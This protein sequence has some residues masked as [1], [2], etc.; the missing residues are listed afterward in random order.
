MRASSATWPKTLASVLS[1]RD[2]ASWKVTLASIA[3]LLF[4]SPCWALDKVSL[5]LKW[6]H[7]FQFAGYYAALE[8]GFYRDA[9][10][11][12]EIREGGPNIDAMKAVEQGKADFG[13]CTT[14]VLLEKP[15]DPR[16][17]VLG[18]I[19]QHSPAVILVPSRVRIGALS[20]L[21]GRRFMDSP[22]SGDIAAMLKHE[23]IDYASLPR[24]PHD[25]D[26]RDLVTGKADIMIAYSTNEPFVLDQL[27]IPYQTFSPRQFGFDFYGDNLCTSAQQIRAHPERTRAFLAAS[28][29]GWDYALSHKNGMAQLILNRYSKKKTGEALLFEAVQSETLIEPRLIPIGSQTAQRWQSIANA[30]RDLGMLSD[31]RLPDGLIYRTDRDRAARWLRPALLGLVLLTIVS[32]LLLPLYKRINRRL[33]L[34]ANKPKLSTIMAGVFVCLSI[35]ILIFILVYNY[36]RNSEAIL[37]TLQEVVTK[38]RQA[39]IENVEAMI[40]DVAGTLGLLAEMA[41][42][43]PS[44]FRTEK[45]RDVLYRAVTSAAEIDAAYVSFEDGYHRVVTRIDDDRRRADPKIPPTANW[46]SSFIDDFSLGENRRRHRT[47]FDTWGHVV[48]EYDIATDMDIRTLPGYAAAKESRGLVVT[49]PTINPDT[50]YAVIFVRVPIFRKG[51]F[52]GCATAN[53]TFDVLSRF[54]ATHRASQNGTTIIADPANGK[55]IAAS[56]KAKTVQMVDG[57]LEVARLENIADDDVREAYRLQTQTSQDDFLFT[58]PKNGQE[59]SASFARFPESFGRPWEAIVLTPTN[60][61]IGHLKTT[62]Q[63][64]VFI[65]VALSAVELFLIHLLSKRLSQPIESVSRDLKAVETLSFEQPANRPSKVREIAQLQSAAS[66]LRNSLQSFSLFAPVDVVRG[67]IKSGIP[68]ALGVEKRFVTILFADLENFSTYAEQSE[69]D[70]LLDQMSIYF[71]EVSRAISDE[72]GTVDK[73][74][75]DGIMAFWGAPVALPDHVLRACAGALR[76]ARRMGRLNETWR[77]EGRPTFRIRIGL[78]SADVLVGN[79]G[80]SERFSY[81]VIGDGVNVAARLEG[82]NKTFDTA[83]CISDSVF[84]AVTSEIVARPLRRVRVKRR[85]QDFMVY[86]LLGIVNSND[87]ELA[88]RPDDKRLAQMTCE[89][90]GCFEKGDFAEATRHYA[91]I[92]EHFPKDRVAELLLDAA[93]S[94]SV[95]AASDVDESIGEP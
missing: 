38:T 44:F 40:R 61:F 91:K 85:K 66:L 45:S 39:S 9:G 41:A 65:I 87:P 32:V 49:E 82:I 10:L 28:L 26:P 54:L 1:R 53:I 62:N 24:V 2:G 27:G 46:H 81:T 20:E 17:V 36:H 13:V 19:F 42:T 21:K 18:V 8:Q 7:Q 35:P 48:G 33:E 94:G 69:P 84:C 89:A 50:G 93:S 4:A 74:I 12:V 80:S 29:K 51:E 57:Q 64:I 59:L 68:L 63:Q 76:A 23:G 67:L 90:S 78:N 31:A 34:A 15:D 92:L 77:A 5:Q 70:D 72:K 3:L 71:E 52:I 83:I 11:D 14:S 79:I 43:D 75:G 60:D 56:E 58:S 47:F 55:I 88:A 16:V 73:F 22:D 6:F 95:A 30:Y 37:A 86:E 25:G